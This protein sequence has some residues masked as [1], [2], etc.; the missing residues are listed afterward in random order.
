MHN[1]ATIPVNRQAGRENDRDRARDRN[2]RAVGSIKSA[3][4]IVK[5]RSTVKAKKN[6][7][8]ACSLTKYSTIGRG[9]QPWRAKAK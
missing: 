3:N 7:K 5:F 8:N 9:I 1:C 6:M 4:A 2:G